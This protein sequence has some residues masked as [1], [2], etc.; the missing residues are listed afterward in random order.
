[1]PNDIHSKTE[2][3]NDIL[4][5]RKYES[6]GSVKAASQVPQ[7][8]YPSKSTKASVAKRQLQAA[9]ICFS[10]EPTN[11]LEADGEDSKTCQMDTD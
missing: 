10:E 9:S 11:C 8:T 4:S 2:K 1:M 5:E 6:D 3:I 7:P